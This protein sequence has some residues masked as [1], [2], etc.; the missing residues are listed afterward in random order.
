MRGGENLLWSTVEQ[1]EIA[2]LQ[3]NTLAGFAVELICA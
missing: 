1:I 3:P 2:E